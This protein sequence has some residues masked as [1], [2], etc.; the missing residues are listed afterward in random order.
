VGSLPE[1]AAAYLA[2]DGR[3][4]VRRHLRAHGLGADLF[5]DVAQDALVRCLSAERR[6]VEPASVPA[7][8]SELVRR[9]ARD[10]LRGHLRRPEG[11][12]AGSP[13][14]A[15]GEPDQL[16]D[17]E[18]ADRPD[19]EVV[20]AHELARLGAVVDGLRA[21]LAARLARNPER[22][23]G[24]LV[25]LAIAH[26]DATPAADCPSPD[27]GVAQ[28]EALYWAGVF[29]GGPGGCFP[30]DGQVDDA[31]MRQRRSRA[32]RQVK[33]T[34]RTVAEE[35]GAMPGAVDA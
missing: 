34:L 9:S 8:V 16:D 11:H 28:G 3:Q 22:A 21:Q 25:V 29:Y 7:F 5:D 17:I 14:G 2:G 30:L 4:V 27:G 1:R 18:A 10:L 20:S 31:A 13:P 6:G 26:G 12:L 32:L 15:N 23:A 33:A 24:A 19:E 35:A